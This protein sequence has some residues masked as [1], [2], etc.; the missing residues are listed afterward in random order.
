ML[1][2]QEMR[3]KSLGQ[4][5]PLE[6]EM[7]IQS[8]VLPEKSHGQRS[9]A[10]C[11][12]CNCKELDMTVQAYVLVHYECYMCCRHFTFKFNAYLCMNHL[13]PLVSL[14]RTPLWGTPDPRDGTLGFFQLFA[15]TKKKHC[16]EG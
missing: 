16:H 13:Q 11:S 5:D 15:I 12:S 6:E 9:L 10:G 1:G 14:C 4:G 3:A 2:T 8:S 7:A